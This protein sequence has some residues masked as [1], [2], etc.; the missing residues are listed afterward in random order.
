MIQVPAGTIATV[1]Q[2]SGIV[3]GTTQSAAGTLG[4]AAGGDSA[5]D[6]RAAGA[7]SAMQSTWTKQLAYLNECDNG[8]AVA[9]GNAAMSYPTNDAAQMVVVWKTS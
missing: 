4:G 3:A 2:A 6:P 1:Q 8:L 7:F 9:L 5:C